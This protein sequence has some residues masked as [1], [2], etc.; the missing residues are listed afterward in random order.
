MG[1]VLKAFKKGSILRAQ[2]LVLIT[3]GL[4]LTGED[5]IVDTKRLVLT[6]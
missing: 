4:V 3:K 1:L 6:A 2:F 5:E